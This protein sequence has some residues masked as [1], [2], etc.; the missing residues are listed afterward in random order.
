ML[1]LKTDVVGTLTNGPKYFIY[2]FHKSPLTNESGINV[3]NDA[4]TFFV[5][6]QNNIITKFSY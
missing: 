5:N 3:T 2:V 4:C 1:N 6:K